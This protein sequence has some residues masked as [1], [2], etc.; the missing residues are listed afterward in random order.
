[1]LVDGEPGYTQMRREMKREEGQFVADYDH[2]FTNGAA[3]PTPAYTGPTDG[4]SWHAVF[5][6]IVVDL[7]AV[8]PPPPD[9]PFT[10]VMTWQA[11]AA[12]KYRGK[13]WRQKDVEFTKF[14]DLPRRCDAR[15]DLA[16]SG[17]SAPRDALHAAGWATRSAR[18]TTLTYDAY[19]DY[20]ARSAGE[21]SVCKQAYVALSTGWFSDRSAAYLAAGRPVVMQ[22]TGFSAHL[23]CGQGLFAVKTVDEAADAIAEIRGDY[24]RHSAA[25]RDLARSGLDA[26]KVL[27]KLLRKTGL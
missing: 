21:F 24:G 3:V 6:P 8:A 22:E 17:A 25:A 10:G 1:V 7:I 23:P 20:I 12:L 19:H 27:A 16:L 13:V 11:H 2:Y 9:A 5:N 18:E 14:I 15:F 26:T 4:V